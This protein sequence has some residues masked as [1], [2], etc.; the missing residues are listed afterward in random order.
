MNPVHVIG[1]K[2]ALAGASHHPPDL[3]VNGTA[4][5]GRD[6]SLENGFAKS[7][8]AAVEGIAGTERA[9]GHAGQTEAA[10]GQGSCRWST[11]RKSIHPAKWQTKCVC[12]S[13]VVLMEAGGH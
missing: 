1:G 13:P 10:S 12:R 4:V 5:C 9:G 6:V 8:D 7:H 2:E 3:E 11:W